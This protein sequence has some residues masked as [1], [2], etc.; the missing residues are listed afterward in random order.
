[1]EPRR[2]LLAAVSM[3][4]A[5]VAAEEQRDL[6]S[7]AYMYCEACAICVEA[8]KFLQHCRTV[9]HMHAR[10]PSDSYCIICERVIVAVRD[11]VKSDTH[12]R[13][14]HALAM[15][16]RAVISGALW[17][18]GAC[19]GGWCSLKRSALAGESA[20]SVEA[21]PVG[22]VRR[23]DGTVADL[24]CNS[25]VRYV[26]AASFRGECVRECRAGPARDICSALRVRGRSCQV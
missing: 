1:M 26:P 22:P 14:E 17:C 7:S 6:A 15:R 20:E 9:A 11:H 8:A 24:Y 19:C 25:C 10:F 12:L 16:V 23:A 21:Q 3:R 13:E 5:A 4:A 2:I 18:G